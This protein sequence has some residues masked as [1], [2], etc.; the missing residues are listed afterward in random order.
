MLNIAYS[1]ST[2]GGLCLLVIKDKS[3][4]EDYYYQGDCW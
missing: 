3:R 4:D 2:V 1:I